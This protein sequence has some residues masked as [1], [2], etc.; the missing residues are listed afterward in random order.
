MFSIEMVCCDIVFSEKWLCTLV[1][2]LMDFKE[3]TMQFQHAGQQYKFQGITIGSPEI[4]NSHQM[5]KTLQKCHFGIISHLHSI[6]AI[7][8]PLVHPDL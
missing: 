1:P 6:Q 2:I 3:L 8:T 4:I 7:E 5:E